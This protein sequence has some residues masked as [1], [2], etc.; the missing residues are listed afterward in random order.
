MEI[1]DIS[2][3]RNQGTR[4]PFPSSGPVGFGGNRQELMRQKLIH[5]LIP[6]KYAR[7]N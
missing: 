6:Q 7:L 1:F 3:H 2:V 4:V 5:A